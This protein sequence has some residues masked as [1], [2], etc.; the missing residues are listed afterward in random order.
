MMRGGGGGGGGR[1]PL[2]GYSKSSLGHSHHELSPLLLLLGS[3]LPYWVLLL[4]KLNMI[5]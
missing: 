2:S 4:S 5:S 3:P 1:H